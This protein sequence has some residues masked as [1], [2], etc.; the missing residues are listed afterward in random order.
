MNNNKYSFLVIKRY[1]FLSDAKHSKYSKLV[2]NLE[3][4]QTI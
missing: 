1:Y 4:M 3:E 2:I